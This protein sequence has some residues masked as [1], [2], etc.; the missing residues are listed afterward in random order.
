ML[1][2][3][4]FLLNRPQ[5]F[6]QAC[7]RERQ[8]QKR[9]ALPDSGAMAHLSCPLLGPRQP[10]SCKSH[11]EKHMHLAGG[12]LQFEYPTEQ[13]GSLDSPMIAVTEAERQCGEQFNQGSQISHH[14]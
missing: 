11:T 7:R 1:S 3:E 2:R 10:G 14:S 13:A 9:E 6:R 8:P 4:P 12:K 5:M